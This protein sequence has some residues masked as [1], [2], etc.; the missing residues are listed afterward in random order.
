MPL[1]KMAPID[2]RRSAFRC[3]GVV[4]IPNCGTSEYWRRHECKPK[5]ITEILNVFSPR[6]LWKVALAAGISP[7]LHAVHPG[8]DTAV[9]LVGNQKAIVIHKIVEEHQR[10]CPPD[11]G[12]QARLHIPSFLLAPEEWPGTRVISTRAL[13]SSKPSWHFAPVLPV[14]GVSSGDY[15]WLRSACASSVQ[16]PRDKFS[17]CLPLFHAPCAVIIRGLPW[18]VIREIKHPRGNK[19]YL[20]CRRIE[21]ED[22]EEMGTECPENAQGDFEV[23]VGTGEGQLKCTGVDEA[24][25]LTVRGP[26]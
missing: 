16:N 11:G 2:V 10:L 25:L 17:L 1:Q 18:I 5:H 22:A 12:P 8:F 21:A 19:R 3:T 24:I 4:A 6:T 13:G 7:S 20:Y 9:S 15:A 23:Y 26:D 14:H